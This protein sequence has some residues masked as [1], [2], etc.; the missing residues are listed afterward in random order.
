MLN[1]LPNMSYCINPDCHNP[2]N[3]DG[4]ATCISCGSSLLLK[5]R[6]QVIKPL[7]QSIYSRTFLAKDRDK[8]A[9]TYCVIKQF[10]GQE[11]VSD[12]V[13]RSSAANSQFSGDPVQLD[14][15]G[16]HP[17]IPELLAAF[18][19]DGHFYLIQEY[20]EGPSLAEDLAEEGVFGEAQVWEVL[21][22][23]LPV[24]DY[25]HDRQVIHG[26]IKPENILC[27]HQE[28]TKHPELVLVDFGASCSVSTELQ[29]MGTINGSAEYVAPEQT[30]GTIYPNSDLYSLGVTCIHLLT[31]VPPFDLFDV[32]TE[33]WVWRDYLKKPVS[34]QLG[35]ILDKLIER[36]PKQRYKS[37]KQVLGDLKYG[38]KSIETF[39]QKP[40]YALSLWTG[41][42]IALLS[43]VISSRM[44]SPTAKTAFK[45]PEPVSNHPNDNFK[46][47]KS[48]EFHPEITKIQPLPEFPYSDLNQPLRTLANNSKN[49][50][51]IA[52]S[53][54]SPIVASGDMDG[55]IEIL[56]LHTGKTI[57]TLAGHYGPVWSIAISSDGQTLVSGGGDGTVKV[58]NLYSGTLEHTL[59]GH[60]AAVFSVAISA[61]GRTI[62][63]GS[64]DKTI[65]L[66]DKTSGLPLETLYGH[67][68]EVQSVA[69]SPN[70][71]T[72]VSGSND[73]TVKV[74]NWRY[75]TAVK[76]FKGHDAPV[77]A[78]AISPDG[79]TIASGSWDNTIKLWD[80]NSSEYRRVSWWARRTLI[81]HSEKVQ[82]LAF[83]P[84][85]ETLASGD[86][87]GT[88]KL[89]NLNTGNMKGTLKGHNSWVDLAFDPLSQNLIS[90]SF[91]DTI[92][93]WHLPRGE[94]Y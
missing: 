62:A 86:F 55:T 41:A 30:Q 7:G 4:N 87:T 92:K 60:Q 25:M 94:R 85:G 45:L 74:W 8:P 42:A 54:N 40:K 27:R 78:V 35:T 44:P 24:L 52:V 6:Y 53:P 17:Q 18:E 33:T 28:T 88:I 32:K 9:K 72:L 50:W 14:K 63:S 77:W 89:W 84:D 16:K 31:E 81:G 12:L 65:K 29:P 83:S 26:D 68:D 64:K 75:A 93:V 79:Q 22:Q 36:N 39:L 46:P 38:P 37:A 70:G 5:N 10:V 73:G 48:Q 58:W 15:V 43:L 57:R 69:F 3:S 90:G 67:L 51:S 11:E 19:E 82:S 76:T 49:V 23:V 1:Y 47:P 61:D 71:E 2:H 91:D 80:L 34:S 21:G 13:A 56:H 59:Y 20:V 66:W